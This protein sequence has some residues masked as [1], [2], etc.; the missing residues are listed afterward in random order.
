MCVSRKKKF[1][2][3]YGNCLNISEHYYLLSY[4]ISLTMSMARGRNEKKKKLDSIVWCFCCCLYNLHFCEH[5][6]KLSKKKRCR[7]KKKVSLI[8]LLRRRVQMMFRV[9]TQIT[10]QDICIYRN[11]SQHNIL[12]RLYAR[13]KCGK[14]ATKKNISLFT[15]WA[16]FLFPFSHFIAFYRC[17]PHLHDPCF[18]L[19]L[20][21]AHTPKRIYLFYSRARSHQSLSL[22]LHR[23]CFT[24][25]NIKYM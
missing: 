23:W 19:C 1:L 21:R 14:R 8:F 25:H 17:Q 7:R 9:K 18:W 5:I 16:C 24:R 13:E 12:F 15:T 10:K 3:C 6:K 20:S 22:F 11:F 4:W 2:Q